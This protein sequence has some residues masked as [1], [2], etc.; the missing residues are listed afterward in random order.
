MPDAA[1]AIMADRP[2]IAQQSA[3]QLAAKATPEHEQHYLRPIAEGVHFTSLALSEA[4][5]GVHFYFPQTHL[6]RD[7]GFY[8]VNG[9]KQFVTSGGFADSYVVTTS[10][11]RPGSSD[12]GEFS[13][14][15]LEAAAATVA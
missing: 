3:M 8:T 4:G 14:L 7:N 13:A 9:T 5:T 2:D 11:A 6:E 12:I 15:V 10:S 1:A